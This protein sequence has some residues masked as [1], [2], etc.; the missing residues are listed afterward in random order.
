MVGV[1]HVSCS[2]RVGDLFVARVFLG[3]TWGFDFVFRL[4]VLCFGLCLG[5]GF[6]FACDCGDCSSG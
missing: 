2:F 1:L 6:D 3:F 5:L 4:V